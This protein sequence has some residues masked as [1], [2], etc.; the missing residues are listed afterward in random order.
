MTTPNNTQADNET[1]SDTSAESA[2]DAASENNMEDMEMEAETEQAPV[3]VTLLSD[4]MGSRPINIQP[5]Q[6]TIQN[7]TLTVRNILGYSQVEPGSTSQIFVNNTAASL[8]STVA[9]GDQVYVAG[10]LAGGTQETEEESTMTNQANITENITIDMTDP[11][12]GIVA[13]IYVTLL[14][15]TM[16]SRPINIRPLQE[17]VQNVTL[18]V[19]NVLGY[20]QVEPGGTAQIFVNN[21]VGSLDSTVAEGD[22]IYVAGKL[23]GGTEGDEADGLTDVN[24][25]EQE[26][27]T[28]QEPPVYVTLLSDTQG[29]RPINIQPLQ[30]NLPGHTLT[31]RNVL[32]YAQAE[33][34]ATAQLFLNNVVASL[35][36]TIAE[37][38]MIYVAGKLA[39]GS[40]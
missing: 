14:S 35:D 29:S 25:T 37:G 20:A 6:E 12:D 9:E 21:V 16:G 2:V 18:T 40:R 11:V 8:D 17:G 32:G 28:P 15:D 5:L 26:T 1:E 33:P 30:T 31:I 36:S 3:Y 23:A 22:L 13:G 39:G 19:R 24:N 34:G 4:T 7:V 10:K 38:D 27:E